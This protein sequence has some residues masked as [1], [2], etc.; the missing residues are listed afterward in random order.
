MSTE[1]PNGYEFSAAAKLYLCAGRFI[2]VA[3]II[4]GYPTP[5]GHKVDRNTLAKG[6]VLVTLDWIEQHEYAQ[7]WQDQK[8]LLVGST[9]V[10]KVRALY[11]DGPGFTGRFLK[12][13]R[14][15]DA[16]LIGMLGSLIKDDQ[17]PVIP[18][19]DSLGQ[20]FVEAGI[21]TR[22]GYGAHGNVWN[23]EWLDYL[24]EAWSPE[25]YESYN[26]AMARPDRPIAERNLT[27]ALAACQRDDDGI[28]LDD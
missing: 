10:V 18:F 12:A 2:P 4:K 7:V 14:W 22:G 13:T 28:D 26:H 16:D 6:V 9:P 17:A 23:S 5:F 20:E 1:T 11:S 25:V 19:L 15:Q 27:H 21:L 8:R 24:L 3:G